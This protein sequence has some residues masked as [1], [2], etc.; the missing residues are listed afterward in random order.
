MNLGK[1]GI[2]IATLDGMSQAVREYYSRSG[3]E[4]ICNEAFLT[5]S[6]FRSISD[7]YKSRNKKVWVTLEERSTRLR[8]FAGKAP[9]RLSRILEG[10]LRHDLL[11][12]D[13]D[14]PYCVIEVKSHPTSQISVRRD[15][16]VS[17]IK[18]LLNKGNYRT[19]RFGLFAY[20]CRYKKE[21][22]Y[23]SSS[24][25]MI[26]RY[27]SDE[28]FKIE[29]IRRKVRRVDEHMLGGEVRVLKIEYRRA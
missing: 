25:D 8:D 7:K 5:A 4:I 14:D 3:W 28:N 15:H 12:W 23:E 17:R 24:K 22:S 6:V 18:A 26:D 21:S 11:V 16:D 2:T 27:A 10:N 29:L 9:G 13:G 19:L 20:Y 1:Q